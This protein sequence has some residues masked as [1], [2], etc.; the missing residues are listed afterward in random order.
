MI[1]LHIYDLDGTI[2]DSMKMWDRISPDYIRS[3]GLEADIDLAEICDP[4]TFGEVTAYLAERYRIDG[5]SERVRADLSDY[6]KDMYFNRLLLFDGIIQELDRVRGDKIPMIIFSNTPR[7]LIEAAMERTGVSKYFERIFTTEEMGM[8]K[9]KPEV[10]ERVCGICGVRPG[11]SL[12][13][14]DSEYAIRAAE[15]AGCLIEVY[16][17]YR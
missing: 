5:G 9:D 15:K 16:D 10:F 6:I 8:R 11:E 4:M 3:L 1:K 13:H 12:V 14:E 2:L 17:R 7:P